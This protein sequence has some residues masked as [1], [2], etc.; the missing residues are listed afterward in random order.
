[1]DDSMRLIALSHWSIVEEFV[2]LCAVKRQMK[3]CAKE[4]YNSLAASYL[5]FNVNGHL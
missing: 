5:L 2:S 4:T 1:M 3:V